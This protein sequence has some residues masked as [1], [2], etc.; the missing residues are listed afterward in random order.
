MSRRRY[1]DPKEFLSLAAAI[2][3]KRDELAQKGK[4]LLSTDKNILEQI[5]RLIENEFSFVL[6]IAPE[7]VSDYIKER[8]SEI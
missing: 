8:L 4:R 3:G 6:K 2:Y 5:E 1:D 7:R